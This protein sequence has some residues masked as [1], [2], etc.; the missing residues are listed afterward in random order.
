M[1]LNFFKFNC[2][3][4]KCKFHDKL[5]LHCGQIRC[6]F[7]SNDPLIISNHISVF[8]PENADIP[9]D[10]ELYHIDVSCAS[11]MCQFNTSSTHW[12]CI[13]CQAGF[14]I[15]GLHC[16]PVPTSPPKLD[17]CARPFCK[18]KKKAHFH[19]KTCDQGFSNSTKLLNHSHRPTTKVK[20]V[21]DKKSPKAQVE[22]LVPRDFFEIREPIRFT[23]QEHFGGSSNEE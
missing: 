19:C 22:N 10:R 14:E 11:D 15:V 9:E 23:M 16:C 17:C 12:H 2:V 5:H 21:V 1:S 7:A 3:E 8:H 4:P 20:R 18:L 13:R 6:H